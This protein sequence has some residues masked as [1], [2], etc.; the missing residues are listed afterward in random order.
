M[1]TYDVIIIGG[2]IGGL[3][4]ACYLAKLGLRVLL[5]EK[6]YHVGGY[7]GSFT[8]DGFHFDTGVHS[9]GSLKR[10]VLKKIFLE[11]D[12]L[13]KIKLHFFDTTDVIITPDFKIKFYL[14]Y[15]RTITDLISV[16]PKQERAIRNFF[17]FMLS[18]DFFQVYKKI[19]KITFEKL[20]TSFFDESKLKFIFNFLIANNIG[21]PAKSTSALAAVVLFR[22]YIL[23]QGCYPI[24]GMQNFSNKLLETFSS[25]GGES[26]LNTEVQKIIITN[27]A[28]NGVVTTRGIY[29]AK[30]I[31]SSIDATMTFT[32]LINGFY[33]ESARVKTFRVT[34]SVLAVFLG[35]DNCSE[36][37]AHHN[38]WAISKYNTGNYLCPS[39]DDLRNNNI[40]AL[41]I[42]QLNNGYAGG[43]DTKMS[44]SM[45]LLVPYLGK[46]FWVNNKEA[47]ADKMLRYCKSFMEV[48][49][50]SC[51]SVATP[52]TYER[53]T[54][55]RNGA[56]FGW[57]S[58]NTQIMAKNFPLHTSI[59]NLFLAGHWCTC[60]L[61]QAGVPGAALSGRRVSEAIAKEMG[62]NWPY[63]LLML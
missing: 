18:S 35:I 36:D 8:R 29:Y 46:T 1:K 19:K 7:C 45:F 56:A 54:N 27:G 14:N 43:L 12:F 59:R 53:Y 41:L 38:V 13:E 22:Q 34:P 2:G 62:I 51:K 28:A 58:T 3:V 50:Y 44:L 57:K 21:T 4:S 61:G 17:N 25:L 52:L 9:L 47:V 40:S 49:D 55:N 39:R 15:E 33:R 32:K 26:L 20:L 10:G 16:F 37:Y 30:K 6:Q 24:G 31:I 42:S 48:R 63:G 23:D 5:I 60:G 11:L